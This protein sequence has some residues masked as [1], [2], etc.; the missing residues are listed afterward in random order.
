M[1]VLPSIGATEQNTAVPATDKSNHTEI[2]A[3][4]TFRA[5]NSKAGLI[6]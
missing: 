2:S 1:I 5:Q 4:D 6:S 3:I